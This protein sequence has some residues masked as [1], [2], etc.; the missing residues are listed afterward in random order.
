MGRSAVFRPAMAS[1]RNDLNIGGVGVMVKHPRQVREIFPTMKSE[2]FTKGRWIH[3]ITEG[4]VGAGL[5]MFSVYGYDTGK[6]EHA[7]LNM[8]LDQEVFGAIAALD[9]APWIIG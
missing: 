6:P 9:G 5:H 2:H 8:E 3:A 7:R 4:T 1:T